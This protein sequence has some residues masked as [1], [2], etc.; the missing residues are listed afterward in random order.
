MASSA[1]AF[2]LADLGASAPSSF[3]GAL[4]VAGAFSVA[5]TVAMP[6]YNAVV[7]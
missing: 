3:P 2:T 1:A 4:S 5:F 7:S 6:A